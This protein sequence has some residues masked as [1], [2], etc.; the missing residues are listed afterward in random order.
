MKK[1]QVPIVEPAG[2]EE[3]IAYCPY[4]KTE[5]WFPDKSE[6]I[7]KTTIEGDGFTQYIEHRREDVVCEACGE[8]YT[9]DFGED[10]YTIYTPPQLVNSCQKRLSKFESKWHYDFEIIITEL[11]SIRQEAYK[12]ECEKDE[13]SCL[14]INPFMDDMYKKPLEILKLG[15]ACADHEV[16]PNFQG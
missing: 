1:E 2:K 5:H 7:E 16:Y 4:C 10:K 8:K 3:H 15:K 11:L 6:N 13:Y 12:V 14:L 9:I